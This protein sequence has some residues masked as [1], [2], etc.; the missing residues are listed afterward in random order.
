MANRIQGNQVWGMQTVEDKDL[1]NVEF[2]TIFSKVHVYK[3][4][5]PQSEDLVK[6]LKNSLE[7][8]ASSYSFNGWEDWFKYGKT[9]GWVRYNPIYPELVDPEK[10]EKE[11]S[12]LKELSQAFAIATQHY[13]RHYGVIKGEDWNTMGPSICMYDSEMDQIGSDVLSMH[14]H[15]DYDYIRGDEPGDKFG[16]TCTMYLNDDYEGGELA[17]T[18]GDLDKA[19]EFYPEPLISYK[20]KAGEIVVFPSGHPDVMP[21][22][23]TYFH[24]VTKTKKSKDKNSNKFFIRSYYMI[25]FEG[26]DEWLE[27][28]KKYGA[29]VWDAMENERIKAR[30]KTHS[31]LQ[32]LKTVTENSGKECGLN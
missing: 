31:Q 6:I 23:K 16:I 13:M 17:F 8:K 27:N 20:P 22:D 3:N 32:E 15:R 21:E 7:D 2:D 18:L 9:M 11:D 14:Y 24:G 28:Q 30:V 29:E 25:P 12:I 26:T 5:L 1:D 19:N 10:K 4:L